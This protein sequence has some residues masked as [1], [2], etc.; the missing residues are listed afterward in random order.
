MTTH[1]ILLVVA[2]ERARQDAKWGEQ[3]HDDLYWL[4]ILMEE[5][6]EAAKD[7]IENRSPHKELIEV[8]AV[9]VAW[10]EAITRRKKPAPEEPQSLGD[11]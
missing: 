9:A 1:D 4:G 5:V 3:N 11:A 8:A 7:V 2:S 6:G 10:V